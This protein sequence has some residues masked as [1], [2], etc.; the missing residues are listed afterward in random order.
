MGGKVHIVNMK[1]SRSGRARG[2]SC[3][4]LFGATGFTGRAVLDELLERGVEVRA[5][6]RKPEALGADRPGLTRIKGNALD[7]GDVA[8]CLQGTDAVLHCL[9]VGGQGN[10]KPTFLVSKSIEIL[11]D[12]MEHNGPKRIVC[13]S[14]MGAGGSGKWIVNK[15]IVPLFF[16][17]L[18]PIIDDKDRME[19]LLHECDLEWCAI[20]FPNIIEGESAPV[21]VNDDAR[22]VALKITTESAAKLLVDQTLAQEMRRGTPAASN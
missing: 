12:E 22:K 11:I 3:V 6:L 1:N 5:L 8:N 15:L 2:I 18:M 19:A 20:R 21:Q 9:G 4:A 13:M 14:N 10:G 17:W 16:R 7:P